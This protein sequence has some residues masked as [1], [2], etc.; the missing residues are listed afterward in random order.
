[1]AF[2]SPLES[3]TGSTTTTTSATSMKKQKKNHRVLQ[4]DNDEMQ[5]GND[6]EGEEKENLAQKAVKGYYLWNP[7]QFH[8]TLHKWKN[9]Y[10]DLIKITTAQEKYGLPAAGTATDCSFYEKDGC[11]NYMFTIQ[12]YVVH[13][14]GS[15]SSNHLP[16]VLWSGCLHGNERV[17]PTATMEAATLLLEAAYC[18]GLPRNKDGEHVGHS[19]AHYGSFESQV[20]EAKEC[21]QK[22]QDKGVG[23]KERKWL[24]RLVTTR[25]IVVVPTANALG[26]FQ[27]VRTEGIV[28]PNRDFPYDIEDPKICMQ[29]IAGR[30]L[31]EIYRDHMFQLALTF[32]AGMEVVAYEWG[33]PTWLNKVSPDDEAQ[34]QIASA[35][36]RFGGGWS[37]S[38]PYNFGTMNDLVYY[39]RGGMEDWAYAGSW[40]PDR[41]IE[42]EPSTYGGYP[43]EKT[44]YNNS[45]LRVF[46]MLVETSDN[47]E[48]RK[49]DLGSSLE[50]LDRSTKGNGHVSRNIRLALLAADMVEPY[51][52]IVG[53]NDLA[54]KDDLPPLSGR[55]ERSCQKT[56]AFLVAKNAEE[57]QIQFT[58]GGAMSID[59]TEVWFAKW[60]DIPEDQLD[61]LSQPTSTD[62][63]TKGTIIGANNGTGFF[64][65]A[66][67]HPRSDSYS[68]IGMT[69]NGPIFTAKIMVP[70]RL[71]TLDQLVVIASAKVDQEWKTQPDN[72]G[73]NID[74]QSHI[75]NARTNPD[76]H[77]ESA[78]KHIRG[79]LDWFSSPVTIVIGDFTDSVGTQGE[80]LVRTVEM[81]PRFSKGA[82]TSTSGMK[83]KSA[84]KAQLWFPVAMWQVLAALLFFLAVC[85]CCV[86][87]RPGR[88]GSRRRK[89][90][91]RSPRG[92]D[93]FVFDSKPY[94]DG[95]YADDDSDGEVELPAIA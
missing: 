5:D 74:P 28:D 81:Y 69:T 22:L 14:E 4:D 80:E 42:C 1:V 27:N 65:R 93:G 35:Y 83:P 13:P 40:D 56:K 82:S 59:N 94:S 85:M 73:P 32:H 61:C 75:V 62:G 49:S 70:S 19:I 6:E 7:S 67:S 50:V 44:V 91:R 77:H 95:T 38:K 90:S 37:K 89:N 10:P 57:V 71:K 54:I 26:Y 11:P 68:D 72:I 18:E 45:T 39:V 17:G 23:D 24:A 66:G 34:S 41:V 52:S 8:T 55:G 79:R 3:I 21:R 30:T 12:D 87:C 78:G 2:A 46:N 58:V 47:K 25:R 43:K 92:D 15:E 60:D 63:F 76:W 64:S 86:M 51:V 9:V 29:T 88:Q 16:E 31:N 53:V 20:E 36:S 84:A 33:A 48:P